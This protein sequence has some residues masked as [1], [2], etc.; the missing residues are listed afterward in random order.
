MTGADWAPFTAACSRA[1]ARFALA[2]T[3]AVQ[4]Q[5]ELLASIVS[6][7]ADCAFGREHDF[8][9]ITDFEAYC[10]QVPVRGHSGFAPRIARMAGG[11]ADC[12][13]SELV[14][15]FEET[16]GTGGAKLVPYTAA[17]LDGFRRA[18]LPWLGDLIA[19][20]PA[21]AR[22]R[23]YL[24]I[25]PATRA[26]QVTPGGLAIGLDS[27]AAY[28]G[29]DLAPALAALLAVPPTLGQL[30]DPGQWQVET[31]AALIAAPDLSF[32]SLWSPTF[33]LAL[34]G[35]L[36]GHAEA[37]LAR[38]SPAERRRLQAAMA[39][40]D[41]DTERLWPALDCISCWCDGISAGY[42]RRLQA[43]F[44]H[45]AIEPKG[46]LATEA[47]VTV[48]WGPGGACVPAVDSC[49][50]EFHDAAG[51]PHLCD[52]LQQ[53]EAYR[54]VV[55]TRSGLYRYD[56]GDLVECVGHRGTV[57][58]LRFIGRAGVNSD[59][60]GEKL[61]DGFVGEA[62]A[63]LAGPAVLA[64]RADPAGYVLV[65]ETPEP[66]ALNRVE[67]AL[68]RN[69]HYAHARRMGQLAP[70]GLVRRADLSVQ[71]THR[72]IAQ[73]RRLGDLKPLALLPLG[74]GSEEWL[75]P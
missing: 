56:L 37:V 66:G 21:L 4:H 71:L 55:S 46:L 20:R 69:P 62:L 6:T 60:V 35:S 23:A 51:T 22:G 49:L 5:R 48:P 67:A 63:A 11:E 41:L 8:A 73:G 27:D 57:P 17:G 30:R 2:L 72:G 7:N 40:A 32:V 53:G 9:A 10:R 61:D 54:I 39:G 16:G 75:L 31:L 18:V 43:Q 24:T 38:L 59:L 29:A 1:A 36:E 28:L 25:S 47:A 50:I 64:A 15:A 44:P 12:L 42:A 26:R 3:N 33:L 52:T 34:L 19:R 45:A 68:A 58:L 70:L 13:T 74:S 65:M 14:I